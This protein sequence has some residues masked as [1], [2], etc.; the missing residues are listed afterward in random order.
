M[1]ISLYHMTTLHSHWLL[2]RYITAHLHYVKIFIT[3]DSSLMSPSDTNCY[4]NNFCSLRSRWHHRYTRINPSLHTSRL[5]FSVQKSIVNQDWS[6][7]C[8]SIN[9]RKTLSVCLVLLGLIELWY[10]GVVLICFLLIWVQMIERHLTSTI[11]SY[12][13]FQ[14][15]SIDNSQMYI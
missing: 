5:T 9:V 1:R 4:W 7:T 13:W 14:E 15:I 10:W 2:P 8:L 3:L 6:I 12:I 11:P